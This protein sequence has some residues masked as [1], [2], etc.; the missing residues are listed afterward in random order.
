MQFQEEV[1]DWN[2]KHPGAVP[3]IDPTTVIIPVVTELLDF[4]QL[5]RTRGKDLVEIVQMD[6]LGVNFLDL[7]RETFKAFTVGKEGQE[8]HICSSEKMHR[9]VQCARTSAIGDLD[10]VGAIAEIVHRWSKGPPRAG[11]PRRQ[12]VRT[13]IPPQSVQY[14]TCLRHVGNSVQAYQ[15]HSQVKLKKLAGL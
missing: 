12:F 14:T 11:F 8:K 9:I 5:L 7:S 2:K 6:K 3:K 13:E 10:N 15:S 4:Y 1:A